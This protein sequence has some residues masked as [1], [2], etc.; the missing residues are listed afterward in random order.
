MLREEADPF[1]EVDQIA[2]ARRRES[3]KPPP[4]Y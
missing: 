4:G 3:R 2:E 1:S